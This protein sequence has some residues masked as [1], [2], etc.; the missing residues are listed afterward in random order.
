MSRGFVIHK[1]LQPFSKGIT[2]GRLYGPSDEPE[3]G[4]TVSKASAGVRDPGS[5]TLTVPPINLPFDEQ[6]ARN[7]ETL[8]AAHYSLQPPLAPL[9]K[10]DT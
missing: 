7:V 4:L 9:Q 2:G 1:A 10:P 5:E 8:D 3:Q 6:G